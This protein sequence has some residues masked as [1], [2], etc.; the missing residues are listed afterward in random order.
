MERKWLKNLKNKN[1]MYYP[2][3]LRNDFRI[4]GFIPAMVCLSVCA[5]IWLFIGREE[6]FISVSIL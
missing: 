5:L 4:T 2:R 1:D 3:K 6:G